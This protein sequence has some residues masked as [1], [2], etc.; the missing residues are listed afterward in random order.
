MTSGCSDVGRADTVGPPRH[1]HLLCVVYSYREDF[2]EEGRRRQGD[3]ESQ[4]RRYLHIRRIGQILRSVNSVMVGKSTKEDGPPRRLFPK[5]RKKRRN[6]PTSSFCLRIKDG[7]L[8]IDTREASMPD[9]LPRL[10]WRGTGRP[11]SRSWI[12]LSPVFWPSYGHDAL[13][14]VD[15]RSWQ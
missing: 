8:E 13:S 3:R 4:C 1:T 6:R 15:G 10:P 5:S 7:L 11:F 9:K 14:R 2:V 12:H